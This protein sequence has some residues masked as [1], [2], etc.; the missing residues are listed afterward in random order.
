MWLHVCFA[1]RPC[2]GW[3]SSIRGKTGSEDTQMPSVLGNWHGFSVSHP[4]SSN[5]PVWP[6]VVWLCTEILTA[7]NLPGSTAGWFWFFFGTFRGFTEGIG[8]KNKGHLNRHRVSC[9]LIVV[10]W[11][12]YLNQY[13]RSSN[14]L[15][16]KTWA[17]LHSLLFV[18]YP[19]WLLN[20]SLWWLLKNSLSPPAS[21]LNNP[22]PLVSDLVMWPH[23]SRLLACQ[24]EYHV[25][26]TL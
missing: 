5:L 9:R 2:R 19:E 18:C 6:L 24:C 10:F 7:H 13:T 4:L 12:Y 14:Q 22:F 25:S 21:N 16:N 26:M 20:F 15:S 1:T 23:T 17:K 8:R 3:R 11:Q